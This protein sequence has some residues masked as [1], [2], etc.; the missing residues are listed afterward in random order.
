MSTRAR[1]RFTSAVRTPQAFI[2]QL[3]AGPRTIVSDDPIHDPPEYDI[4]VNV[5]DGARVRVRHYA[6]P[7][8]VASPILQLDLEPEP[9]GLAIECVVLNRHA[10]FSKAA[11]EPEAAALSVVEDAIVDGEELEASLLW[12]ALGLAWRTCVAVWNRAVWDL[13]LDALLQRRS[14]AKFGTPL[15]NAVKEAAKG[16]SPDFEVEV[17]D[18]GVSQEA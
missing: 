7:Q 13:W 15:L 16:G 12:V 18:P 6:S 11:R 5:D 9:G 8:G 1:Y 2:E 3:L 10:P 17:S 4:L 14:M